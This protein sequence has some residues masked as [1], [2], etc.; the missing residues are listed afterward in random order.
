[1]GMQD[2]IEIWRVNMDYENVCKSAVKQKWAVAFSDELYSALNFKFGNKTV[3]QRLKEEDTV[4]NCFFYALMLAKSMPNCVLK[5]GFLHR[6]DINAEN[7]EKILFA[8]AWV[9]RGDF[10]YDTTSRQVF[11]RNFFY[12]TF[13]AKVYRTCHPND[14]KSLRM[15]FKLGTQAVNNRPMLAHELLEY[16]EFEKLDLDFVKKCVSVL[17]D[18]ETKTILKKNF[19]LEKTK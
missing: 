14:L 5:H 19:E 9:E 18:E 13:D 10:V 6:L 12:K 1:M 15:F 8:H 16:R 3:G 17:D 4:G 2:A 7:G 11:N